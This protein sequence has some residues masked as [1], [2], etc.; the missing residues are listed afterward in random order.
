MLWPL[1]RS[2]LARLGA[3]ADGTLPCPTGA[4]AL[5]GAEVSGGLPAD[6]DRTCVFTGPA[7][8]L[9]EYTTA[10]KVTTREIVSLE[11]RARVYVPGVDDSDLAD[12]DQ[13]LGSLCQAVAV[14]LLDVDPILQTLGM[15]TMTLAQIVELPMELFATPEPAA[16]AQAQMLFR[17]EVST[18]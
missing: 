3:V 2:I 1:K 17:A 18:T 16:I 14:T 13:S 5:V 15:G 11:I 9:R 10:E 6:P 4:S 7:Q 12:L 8:S